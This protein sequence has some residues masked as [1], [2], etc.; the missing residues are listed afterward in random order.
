[1]LISPA[2]A[3]AAGAPPGGGDPFIAQFLLIG[4][5][6]LILYFTLI[7]PQQKRLKEHREMITAVRRG[8][9]VVTGGG[10]IGKVM[11]APEGDDEIEIEIA[12]NVR[13]KILRATLSAVLVKTEPANDAGKDSAKKD[14]AAKDS[15]KK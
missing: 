3:Q 2:Y 11:K 15:E 14:A 9:K 7:R 13:V 5:L 12:D 8:D 4:V 10:I 6:F 1:M